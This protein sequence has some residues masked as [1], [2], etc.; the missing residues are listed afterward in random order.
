MYIYVFE[1]AFMYNKEFFSEIFN[2]QCLLAIFNYIDIEL[3]EPS[4]GDLF[5]NNLEILSIEP[6]NLF[7]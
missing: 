7:S 5:Y 3:N 1:F 6:T 2:Q 4:E